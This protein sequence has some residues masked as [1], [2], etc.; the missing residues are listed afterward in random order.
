MKKK[1]NLY[2]FMPEKLNLYGDI[3]NIIALRKRANDMDIELVIHNIEETEGISLEEMDMFFIGGGSDREQKIATE[4]LRHIKEELKEKIEKGTPGLM[5]CGGY[6]FLG[7][8]YVTLEGAELEGLGIFQFET[9]AKEKRLV[10]NIILDSSE[11]GLIAGFENHSGRT[12]HNEKTLGSVKK[13]YG[14]DDESGKEGL[15]YNNIIGTYLH[16][17]ILPKNPKITD[18]L[19]E[20]SIELKF[21]EEIK[22]KET[23]MTKYESIARKQALNNT[24][25]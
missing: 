17:P 4:K 1:I 3:G 23:P 20:K 15:R 8:K 14:N 21:G 10:G 9:I 12:Y 7:K 2:H 5:I 25:K 11:F 24:E 6:Q 19:L 18:F 13:G 16:G 22:E